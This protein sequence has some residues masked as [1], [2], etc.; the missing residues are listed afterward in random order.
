MSNI[1]LTKQQAEQKVY[2]LTEKLLYV[3]KDFKDVAAGYKEKMKE[4][5]AEIKAIVEE[6]SS[7][8]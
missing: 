6:A 1:K 3:K 4:I 8:Q 5:E 7:T 2:E